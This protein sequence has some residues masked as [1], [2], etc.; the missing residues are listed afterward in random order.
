MDLERDLLDIH[1]NT[2]I[3]PRISAAAACLT[4][5][6]SLDARPGLPMELL[7]LLKVVEKEEQSAR[8]TL[9]MEKKNKQETMEENRRTF[10]AYTVQKEEEA[11][12]RKILRK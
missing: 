11:L 10:F 1:E 4:C 5:Q 3:D 2:C 6:S 9:A 7:R 8:E 12:S